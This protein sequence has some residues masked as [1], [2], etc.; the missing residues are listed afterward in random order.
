MHYYTPINNLNHTTESLSRI[1]LKDIFNE[2]KNN[3]YL[4]KIN[5]GSE[6]LKYFES[7][8]IVSGI[9][10]EYNIHDEINQILVSFF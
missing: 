5:R 8:N 1:I 3:E 7:N 4:V 10:K 9:L 6:F 2:A